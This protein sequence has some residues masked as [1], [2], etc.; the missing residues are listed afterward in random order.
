MILLEDAIR[1]R[2]FDRRG[3]TMLEAVVAAIL[4]GVFLAAVVPVFHWTN[5][6]RRMN[7]RHLMADLE[8][9]NQMELLA[10]LP[11][12]ARTAERMQSLKPSTD[13]IAAIPDAVLKA[14][15]N[16]ESESGLQR[17]SLELTWMNDQGQ[18]TG[19]VRLTAWF[20]GP[21]S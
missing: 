12:T 21:E 10:A 1:S 16:D 7:E 9:S 20:P 6:A 18:P 2:T 14:T 11:A 17:I 13:A 19:P 8:L 5:S 3:T 4:L 15:V